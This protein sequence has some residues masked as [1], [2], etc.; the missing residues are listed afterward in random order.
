MGTKLP[1][2]RTEAGRSEKSKIARTRNKEQQNTTATEEE[3]VGGSSI[4]R[5]GVP[6]H[7]PEV[8]GVVVGDGGWL[9]NIPKH[10]KRTL[11]PHP[12]GANGGIR[13][14]QNA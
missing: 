8:A 5:S 1:Q 10:R 14:L 9:E 2:A 3:G 4:G 12:V 13:G 7:K 6:H 11:R